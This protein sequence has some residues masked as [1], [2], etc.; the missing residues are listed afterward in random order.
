M[1][2]WLWWAHTAVEGVG[3]RRTLPDATRVVTISTRGELPRVCPV[4][5]RVDRPD[6]GLGGFGG[7]GWGRASRSQEATPPSAGV[8]S[9]PPSAPR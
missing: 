6:G 5:P 7:R 9:I 2:G 1:Q 4:V 8:A 3:R